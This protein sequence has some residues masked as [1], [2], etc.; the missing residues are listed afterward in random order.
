[1]A[2]MWP[3]WVVEAADAVSDA[4]AE[5]IATCAA[6]LRLGAG[7]QGLYRIYLHLAVWF[8]HRLLRGA[9][10]VPVIGINGSQGS[11]KSTAAALLKCILTRVFERRVCVFSLDDLY[12]KR[13]QRQVL[14]RDVHPLLITRGVPGTHDIALGCTLIDT[15]RNARVD[16]RTPIPQF[17]KAADEPVDSR[18]WPVFEGRP[19]C[20]VFEGWCVGARPEPDTRLRT[21][22][23]RLE[24]TEDAR[25]IWRG[26]V[27][28]W[29]HDYARLF[30]K[31]DNLMMLKVPSF[32][33]VYEW[34]L[35]QERKLADS[36]SGR[37]MSDEQVG[38]F[39]SHFERLTRWQLEE[40]PQRADVL[41]H[42]D[43]QHRIAGVDFRSALE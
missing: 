39:V 5:Q 20:I 32:D 34:R 10:S 21:P 1:M 30:V 31:V 40:M 41:L 8:E 28:R 4:T 27:N 11:G 17:D 3:A 42:L 16:S 13:E 6:P 19:D 22:I 37:V 2:G 38:R 26:Y 33:Q 15:L 35:L 9:T 7:Y 43:E 24:R 12:L 25:A 18:Q 29:L 14:A 36:A 23:N